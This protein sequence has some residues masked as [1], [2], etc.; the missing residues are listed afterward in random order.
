MKI[1]VLCDDPK[2][3]KAIEKEIEKRGYVGNGFALV[4]PNDPRCY[5]I[6]DTRQ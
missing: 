4:D 6:Q 3:K 5:T 2:L 1:E